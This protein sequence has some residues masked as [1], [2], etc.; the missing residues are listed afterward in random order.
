MPFLPTTAI[1]LAKKSSPASAADVQPRVSVIIPTRNA[2]PRL[3]QTLASITTQELAEPFEVLAIDSGS[4][5]GTPERCQAQ[6]V[7][8]LHIPAR[9]FG[10]GRTRNQAIAAARGELVALTVQDA[11]PADRH[12]LANLVAAL[13]SA[14]Q[15]AGVYSR[16]LPH[17]GASFI[18]R[19]VAEYWHHH[20]GG[21]VE[22]R[23]DDVAAFASLP[24]EEKKQHCTFNDVSS[25]LR[26][27]VWESIPLRDLDFAEDLAWGYDVLCAGHSL[28]YEPASQVY[29]SHERPLSYEFRR[30]YVDSKIVGELFSAPALPLS[31]REALRLCGLWQRIDAR[32]AALGK[33]RH[34]VSLQAGDG[35]EQGDRLCQELG[36]ATHDRNWYAQHFDLDTLK[37]I[38]GVSSPYPRAKQTGIL[39]LLDLAEEIAHSSS[40]EKTPLRPLGERLKDALD[41]PGDWGTASDCPRREPAHEEPLLSD[42]DMRLMFDT[43]WDQIDQ[44]YVRRAVLEQTGSPNDIYSAL[45]T[46]TRPFRD[47]AFPALEE[48]L[49]SFAGELLMGAMVACELTPTLYRDIWRFAGVRVIG[50]RLG[51]ANRYGQAR[52]WGVAL[53]AF[54][55]RGI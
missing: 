13:D 40:L 34:A 46:Q 28:I 31:F 2:G 49:L 37:H 43:L 35:L 8:V 38:L 12:W 21:R 24:L 18:A 4:T 27:R 1:D 20:Q 50:Q 26:R 10:H 53:H 17:P 5:D 52:H 22:Q 25:M 29:H 7:R 15:A 39:Y 32:A 11:V 33:T 45:E 14:P 16:H 9:A 23:I 54:L 51:E 47:P 3:G 41:W 6:G 42:A 48:R 55:R 30:A 44:S 19:Q 36:G